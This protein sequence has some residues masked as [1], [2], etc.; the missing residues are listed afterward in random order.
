MSQVALDAAT[1]TD[2]TME[3]HQIPKLVS[4][5]HMTVGLGLRCMALDSHNCHC[6]FSKA[7]NCS[8]E[9]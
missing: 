2:T 6:N 1:I 7:G 5:A 9:I 3:L 8:E 4:R